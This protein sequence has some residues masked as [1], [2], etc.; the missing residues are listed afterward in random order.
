MQYQVVARTID[1]PGSWDYYPYWAPTHEKNAAQR[2]ANYAAQ[3]GYEAAIL[4]SVTV[5]MLY[6][7]ARRVV[8][9]Q[10]SQLLPS[11]RYLPGTIVTASGGRPEHAVETAFSAPHMLDPYIEG[12]DKTELDQRRLALERGPGGDAMSDGRWRH[13]RLTF[14][15]RMDVL[16]AWLRLRERVDH[17]Q[18][19]GSMD[20]ASDDT[21]LD[22]DVS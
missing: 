15:A 5:E 16:S 21:E 19:G 6:Q 2:L 17:K 12:P 13:E 1:P 14:P 10:D 20:G 4:Q 3:T 18:L 22:E 7:I 8:E 11:L 9:R